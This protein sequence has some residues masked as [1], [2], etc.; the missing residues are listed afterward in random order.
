MDIDETRA[1]VERWAHHVDAIDADSGARKI[2]ERRVLRF[3]IRDE[4]GVL[5]TNEAGKPDAMRS[6]GYRPAI[7]WAAADLAVRRRRKRADEFAARVCAF[8]GL[9]SLGDGEEQFANEAA[10]AARVGL[11]RRA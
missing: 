5:L 11:T 3:V 1:L 8:A 9:D 2:T 4:V 6:R 10:R 7:M